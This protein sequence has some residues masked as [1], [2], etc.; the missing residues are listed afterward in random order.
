MKLAP[1]AVALFCLVLPACNLQHDEEPHHEAQKIVVT[2]PVKK[3]VVTTQQYVCQIHSQRHINIRALENGYLQ[4]ISIKEG[5]TVKAGDELFKVNPALYQ[6]R[7]EAEVAEVKFAEQEYKNSESLKRDNVVS[8]KALQLLAAKLLKAEAK[9]KLAQA[10]LNFATVKAPFDGIIDRLHEQQGSL[11]KEG[12]ILTTLSDNKVMWAY[13]NV[14][15]ARHLDY[16]SAK[17]TRNESRRIELLLANGEIFP[18][19][20]KFGTIE[21]QFNNETGNI[22]YRADF[23]NP[24]RLLRHGQTGVIMIH[25]T[26]KDALVIPQRATYEILDKR[27][28]YVVDDTNTVRQRE[29]VVDYELEDVFVL[30]SGVATGDKIVLEGVRQ[31]RDGQE[32]ECEYR[33]PKEALANQKKYAE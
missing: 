20:G 10:E 6:A 7:L 12:D 24:E 4:E 23:Q 32:I 11:I 13:F 22:A 28:V 17:G 26:V 29:I 9:M 16:E 33:D 27:Y 31:V 25:R 19:E 3:D 5:Q 15:E 14:P 8:A 30:K 18:Q 2:S 21:G 1:P